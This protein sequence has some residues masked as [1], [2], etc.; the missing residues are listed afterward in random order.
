MASHPVLYTAV[1]LSAMVAVVGIP[2]TAV[3]VDHGGH[4][5][6]YAHLSR[7]GVRAGQPVAA[8]GMIGAVGST[9][10]STGCHLHFEVRRNGQPV[11]PAPWL[12]GA[13][14]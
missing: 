14:A 2:D 4:Q 7:V 8:G 11:D 10:N 1:A 9:G 13:P 12:R 3:V 6:W 5:T